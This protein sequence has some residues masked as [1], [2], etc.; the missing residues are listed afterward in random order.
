M[1]RFARNMCGALRKTCVAFCSRT[2]VALCA[3][4]VLRKTCVALCVEHLRRFSQNMWGALRT[5]CVALA[6]RRP[7]SAFG[8][9]ECAAPACPSRPLADAQGP[10]LYAL[11]CRCSSAG[12]RA[13]I[14]F[15][16]WCWRRDLRCPF[17]GSAFTRTRPQAQWRQLHHRSHGG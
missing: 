7:P 6:G 12:C 5:T 15:C 13:N 9:P 11:P 1:W 8:H 17:C 10:T 4:H 16:D 3:E 2:S 14:A